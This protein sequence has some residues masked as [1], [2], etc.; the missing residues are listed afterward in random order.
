VCER[1]QKDYL[2]LANDIGGRKQLIVEQQ[3]N[4]Q[5][6]KQT[7]II[8]VG[9]MTFGLIAFWYNCV[10]NNV[11]CSLIKID[12]KPSI[13]HLSISATKWRKEKERKMKKRLKEIKR[14]RF[15]NNLVYV[16]GSSIMNR[17]DRKL[18][19]KTFSNKINLI[20]NRFE[21]LRV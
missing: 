18:N 21:I 12:Q 16:Q 11:L 17:N 19:S 15:V 1:T 10:H 2:S 6:N 20:Q 4:K 13:F 8:T 5:T 7:E 3:T 14:M 9:E